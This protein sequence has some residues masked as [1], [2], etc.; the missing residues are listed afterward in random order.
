MRL[1]IE[2]SDVDQRQG[3]CHEGRSHAEQ[4]AAVL[5]PD[6]TEA[7]QQKADG[8][9]SAIAEKDRCG[10]EVIAQKGEKAGGERHGGHGKAEIALDKR[11]DDGRDR[12]EET[13]SGG[14]TVESV[15]QV[16]GIGAADEPQQADRHCEPRRDGMTVC[17]RDPCTERNGK[18]CGEELA[19]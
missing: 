3:E 18:P 11:D 15:N 14:Q 19:G 6:E 4:R 13:D 8:E 1:P 10:A 5:T 16:D 17:E 2:K 12:G 7:A 9:A